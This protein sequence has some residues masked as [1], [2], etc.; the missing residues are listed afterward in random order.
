MAAAQGDADEGEQTRMDH[1]ICEMCR[2]SVNTC[3]V[4]NCA[5]AM[6]Q[7]QTKTACLGLRSTV[8]HT[9]A[10]VTDSN[11]A[12]GEPC[13]RKQVNTERCSLCNKRVYVEHRKE[14]TRH[15]SSVARVYAWRWQLNACMLLLLRHSDSSGEDTHEFA[16]DA[17]E[18]LVCSALNPKSCQKARHAC[19]LRS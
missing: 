1:Y 13:A 19:Q 17:E 12:T 9:R 3:F 15:R 2:A 5:H 11:W 4:L 14:L 18:S 16:I 6:C 8:T 7:S 10:F